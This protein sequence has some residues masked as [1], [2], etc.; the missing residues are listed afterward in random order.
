MRLVCPKC[1]EPIDGQNINVQTATAVC[2]ACSEV[3][4]FEVPEP[5]AKSRKR[6][7][8]ARI[9][10]ISED[11]L[12]LR[13]SRVYGNEKLT[14]AIPTTIMSAVLIVLTI[15]TTIMLPTKD[16]SAAL[17]LF[18]GFLAAVVNYLAAIVHFNATTITVED[19]VITVG[20]EGLPE[21]FTEQKQ[22][23]LVEI[24]RLHCERSLAAR[25]TGSFR[26][27]YDLLAETHDGRSITLQKDIPEEYA[28]YLLQELEAYTPEAADHPRLE[29]AQ[30]AEDADE[31][32]GLHLREQHARG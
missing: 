16:Y 29:Q 23:E 30:P 14:A 10:M 13:F 32:A 4:R 12:K 2:V 18:L 15:A 22:V 27:T 5:K 9:Q 19:G 26:D 1:G 7:T 21:P 20:K 6:K 8:P 28:F 31:A 3:F 24:E 11:P 17:P 25:Q